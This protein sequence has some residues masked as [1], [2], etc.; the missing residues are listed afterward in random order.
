MQAGR[1]AEGF[2]EIFGAELHILHVCAPLVSPDVAISFPSGVQLSVSDDEVLDAS[3]RHIE[4]IVAEQFKEKQGIVVAARLGT[5]WSEICRYADEN[6]IDLIIIA[7]HGSTGLR[8]VLIGSTAERVV[9]HA[10]CPVL[11]VKAQERDFT[12]GEA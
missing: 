7:T 3:R 11:S 1:Y 9:R 2:R 12:V 10:G 8:H 5:A 4:S 6:Q